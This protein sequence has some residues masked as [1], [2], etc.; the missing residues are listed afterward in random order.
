MPTRKNFPGRKDVPTDEPLMNGDRPVF[1]SNK[2][3]SWS[4][5]DRPS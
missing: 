4:S 1:M 5:N 2:K 3:S